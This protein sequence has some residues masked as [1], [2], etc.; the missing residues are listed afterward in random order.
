M[1]GRTNARREGRQRRR[2]S[3]R[4]K[5]SGNASRPRLSVFRSL[6]HTYAQLIDD[7]KGITLVSTSTL[8]DDVAKELKGNGG[9]TKTD[10]SKA[11]GKVLARLA[12]EK[13]IKKVC[14]DRGG[15]LY[16]GRVR[17]L[18]DAAREGGLEF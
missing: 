13:G 3:V 14:F 9:H 17:A 4:K 15:Y 1:I 6:K 18:A 7:T 8:S 10:A 5:I 16:H 12:L 2:K 11:V